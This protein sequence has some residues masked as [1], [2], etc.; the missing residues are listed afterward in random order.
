M[1]WDM[2]CSDGYG[3]SDETFLFAKIIVII[4]EGNEKCTNIIY[5][6]LKLSS[7]DLRSHSYRC[8]LNKLLSIVVKKVKIWIRCQRLFIVNGEVKKNTSL[9]IFIVLQRILS[10][11]HWSN[12]IREKKIVLQYFFAMVFFFVSL[13]VGE[14]IS[15]S[16]RKLV[17]SVS[18]KEIVPRY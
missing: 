17:T 14:T 3:A 6:S 15:L 4:W 11:I 16:T 1:S 9:L 2:V 5:Q 10:S 12:L 13:V 8:I 7:R 18:L